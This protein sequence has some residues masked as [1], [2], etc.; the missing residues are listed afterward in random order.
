MSIFVVSQ[1]PNHPNQGKLFFTIK[2]FLLFISFQKLLLLSVLG[3][4][5]TA[6]HVAF[7]SPPFLPEHSHQRLI[8]R[9]PSTFS[10]G[11]RAPYYH[12]PVVDESAVFVE[13]PEI[14][15]R[16]PV[17]VTEPIVIERPIAYTSGPIV[18][19]VEVNEGFLP[20]ET[21]VEQSRRPVHINYQQHRVKTPVTVDSV[22]SGVKTPVM[23][24]MSQEQRPVQVQIVK[25]E[26]PIHVDL[27][28][29]ERPIHLQVTKEEKAV[30]FQVIREDEPASFQIVQEELPVKVCNDFFPLFA[31][32]LRHC[33]FFPELTEI[34]Y[35]G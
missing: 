28:K 33:W 25:K 21:T 26:K 10:Y 16:R 2:N 35:S 27:L 19:E 6:D 13:T 29:K 31:N 20:V 4:S 22:H 7:E 9:H 30:R 23:V 18:K 34:E 8:H 12:T 32:F 14:G 24:D 3:H 5:S 1:I 11:H 17:A 15:I